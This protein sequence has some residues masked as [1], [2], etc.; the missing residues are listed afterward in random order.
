M[1]M[2][3]VAKKVDIPIYDLIEEYS[4]I[5][6][7][8]EFPPIH[9]ETDAFS[10]DG[11][12][13]AKEAV[14]ALKEAI[15]SQK[16]DG[17]SS[18]KGILSAREAVA[19][20]LS[21][22]GHDVNRDDVIIT[23]GVREALAL[24]ITAIANSGDNIL[25]PKPGP[26]YYKHAIMKPAG[27]EAREYLVDL[28]N[29]ELDTEQMRDLIDDRTK[30]IMLNNPHNP[31]GIIFR[32]KNLIELLKLAEQSK[33][34]IIADENYQKLLYTRLGNPL[35]LPQP[36]HF[37]PLA[38]LQPQVPII[39]CDNLSTRIPIA[40]WQLGW[41]VIYDKNDVLSKVKKGIIALSSQRPGPSITVQAALPNIL[42][43]TPNSY[44]ENVQKKLEKNAYVVFGALSQISGVK[45]V[46][47]EA[48]IYMLISINAEKY[49]I[50][51]STREF[52]KELISQKSVYLLQENCLEYTTAFAYI[53]LDQSKKLMK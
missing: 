43:K 52:C 23:T 20:L 16:Y 12:I 9:M 31:T 48:G 42:S 41:L 44:Y 36:S 38:S 27:I 47:A 24:V 21:G 34:P 18:S 15:D 19:T 33:I 29:G 37:K 26:A 39:M 6:N 50:A 49:P 8:P 13:V 4:T 17:Y 28:K 10:L 51:S 1:S 5:Q 11:E 46:R 32:Q 45:P 53:L 22:N 2:S 30:A 35:S 7:N 3:H 40:G 14:K 25:V